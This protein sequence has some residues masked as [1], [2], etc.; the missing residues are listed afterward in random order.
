MTD[1]RFAARRPPARDEALGALR[2]GRDGHRPHAP[3][4][5]EG[6]W[7]PSTASTSPATRSSTR[8]STTTGTWT[9]SSAGSS[10]TRTTTPPCSSSPT[11]AR[12]RMDGG[13]CVNEWLRREGLLATLT[14]PDGRHAARARR[15]R[16]VEDDGLGRG[17]LLL[18][19]LPERRGPRARGDG[20]AGRLRARPRRSRRARSR[21]SRTRTA[22]RSTRAST[23]PRRSTPQVNGV[24]PDLIVHF[25]EPAV[26]VGRHRR[27]RRGRPHVR[28][29]HRARRRQPRAGGALAFSSRRA[30][31]GRRA[32]APICWTWRRPC[33]SCSGS[34]PGLDAG[35]DAPAL[36]GVATRPSGGA[37]GGGP[38]ARAR[39]S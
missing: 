7:T 17:R 22:S 23:S 28:E 37:R 14:E 35:H 10:R 8:S 6:R 36:G 4:L 31:A 30:T 18:P 3:R 25:G 15:R 1:R 9:G 29:R 33:S 21:R 27:R 38:G 16:L 11:T 19:R 12:K 13:I 39:R 32:R 20:R 2:H 34:R 26:A 5:L 24:A